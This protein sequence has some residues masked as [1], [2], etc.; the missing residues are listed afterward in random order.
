[1]DDN[2]RFEEDRRL[3]AE[4]LLSAIAK[5][6]TKKQI[7]RT[8]G[9]S[10]AIGARSRQIRFAYSRPAIGKLPFDRRVMRVAAA[11]AFAH[12]AGHRANI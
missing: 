4:R 6:V 5:M 9:G 11:M 1:V 12:A 3:V 10:A 2:D 8:D 7:R